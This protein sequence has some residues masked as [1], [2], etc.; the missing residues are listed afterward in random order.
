VTAVQLSEV[1]WSS[2]LASYCSAVQYSGVKWIGEQSRLLQFSE[3]ELL[4][5]ETGSWGT[6]IIW[7]PRVRG[8]VRHWMS[9]PG[10]DTAGWEDIVRA[11]V[12]CWVCKSAI[13][14]LFLVVAICAF[15]NCNYQAT[16]T[17]GTIIHSICLS[18]QLK[19]YIVNNNMPIPN[20][21]HW[22]MEGE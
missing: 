14:L 16:H 22:S 13:T 2:S 1:K 15:N 19:T 21:K 10:N 5:L 6:G 3:C 12:N 4:L 11:V 18:L 9:L 20:C 7:E 17:R 8:S